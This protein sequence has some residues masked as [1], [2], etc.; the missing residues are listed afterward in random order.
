MTGDDKGWGAG[1]SGGLP[2]DAAQTAQRLVTRS[3]RLQVGADVFIVSKLHAE[4]KRVRF[5]VER[6]PGSGPGAGPPQRLVVVSVVQEKP[7]GRPPSTDR[8]AAPP[9]RPDVPW[10]FREGCRGG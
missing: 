9:I 1:G 4:E 3:E 2:R 5:V 7:G 10:I 6:T 8:P